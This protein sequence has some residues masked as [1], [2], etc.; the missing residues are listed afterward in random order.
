MSNADENIAY[1][2]CVR[3]EC[4]GFRV[5][6]RKTILCVS[7]QLDWLE[8]GRVG[9]AVNCALDVLAWAFDWTNYKPLTMSAGC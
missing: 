4:S 9:P 5:F 1:T 7:V 2:S 3:L 8:I 6:G